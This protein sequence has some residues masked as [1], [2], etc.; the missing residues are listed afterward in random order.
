MWIGVMVMIATMINCVKI[1][2]PAPLATAQDH[3]RPEWD[4]RGTSA[5]GPDG[6]AAWP[7]PRCGPAAM[8]R[9]SSSGS[10]RS[11]SHSTTAAE[12]YAAAASRNGPAR[13]GIPIWIA[14]VP[15]ALTRLGPAMAPTAVATRTMLTARPRRDGAAR[16]APAYRACKLVDTPAP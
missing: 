8:L 6:A 2:M 14:R 10:G 5:I 12:A 16:S 15:V 3:V 9:A 7:R 11:K 1:R 4:R 13:A